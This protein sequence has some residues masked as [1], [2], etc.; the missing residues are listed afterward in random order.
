M[1]VGV[2]V[3]SYN[4]SDWDRLL[5]ND[6]TTPPK[7]RDAD[8]VDATFAMG[9]LVEPLGFDS[10]WCAE[11]YGSAYSM[12][13]NPLQWLAFWAGRTERV[14]V[15]TAV[16]VA[17]WWQPV[18][19]A[20]EMAMLDLM[21]RGRRLHVGIGRGVAAHEY[22]GFGIPQEQSRVRFREM[23]EILR[24]A[25]EQ[26]SFSYDG[27]AYQV[28]TTSI[29]PQ[30]RHK[31]E[32]TRHILA[33]F[34]TAA[35]MEIAADLGLGQLFVAS[36]TVE[37][38]KTQVGKFNA[39][40]ATKGLA[41]D[42]PTTMGMLHCSTDPDEIE[43]GRMYARRQNWAGR[44]H[45]AVWKA[46]D[47]STVKGYEDYATMMAQKDDIKEDEA[48][49]T[50]DYASLIGTPDEIFEKISLLQQTISLDYLI[51][52]PSHGGKPSQAVTDS[53]RLFAKEVLP[54]VHEMA[55]PLHEH[56]KGSPDLLT[57]EV[58]MGRAATGGIVQRRD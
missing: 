43:Q 23:I 58:K 16:I 57:A 22:A 45:Y 12:Q 10:I 9:D 56:S 40:R 46:P 1:Q 39:I 29:R 32:L 3:T 35:S 47:F 49:D 7:I 33:A 51:V 52:H 48:G 28:P 15:G 14:D 8:I 53:L 6:V 25:D 37:Q 26:E 41:P 5:A 24:Q 19:L 44:N 2:M 18:K 50:L 30:P 31:G 27:E 11:H 4:Q 38:M 20:T 13:G 21:L 54:A 55:T 42:Q 36:E 17:P 34:N